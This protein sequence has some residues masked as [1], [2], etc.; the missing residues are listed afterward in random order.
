MAEKS[1]QSI[2]TKKYY[3]RIEPSKGW[4]R[5]NLREIWNF[6]DL[7]RILVL[8][9]VQLRYKQTALGVTWVVLQPL[10]TSAV[11]A[12]IFGRLGNLPSDD[13]AYELFAFAGMLPWNIF[14]QTLQRAGQSLVKDNQL[15][16]KV[17]FPRIIVPLSSSFSTIIDFV[18]GLGVFFVLLLIYKI[19]F[20]LNF[21]AIPLLLIV[22]LL[23][24]VGVGLWVSAFSVFYR[25]FIYALP[26]VIQIWMYASP[27][28]YSISLIPEEWQNIYALNPMVG[29]VQSFRWILLG[30][31]T[32]PVESLSISILV[33]A[34]IFVSGSIVF[35]RL[36]RNFSDVI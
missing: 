29:V 14:S 17:Y 5:F 22:S 32:F 30:G 33:G 3:H 26:F 4:L 7:L 10:F 9:D 20:T 31:D 21:F 18:I 34:I 8:R 23:I 2:S 28:A 19:P 25:D 27:I 6:R 36:E 15:I 13:V 11:F 24:S 12:L 1:L 16:T 35:K